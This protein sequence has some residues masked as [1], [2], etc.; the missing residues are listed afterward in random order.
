[1]TSMLVT[2]IGELVSWD[3]EQPV[4]PGAAFVVEDERVVR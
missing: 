3:E 4:R 2:N 1:M